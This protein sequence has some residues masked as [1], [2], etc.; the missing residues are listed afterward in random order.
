[1][2]RETVCPDE[3]AAF[4]AAAEAPLA[5]ELAV[6]PRRCALE[7]APDQEALRCQPLSVAVLAIAPHAPTR[8]IGTTCFQET[9]PL[10]TSL[11]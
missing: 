7:P 11:P 9:Q 4:V 2:S 10:A 1:L 3:V 5:G 6:C 8:E